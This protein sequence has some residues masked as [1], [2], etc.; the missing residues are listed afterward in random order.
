MK[1]KLLGKKIRE[2]EMQKIPYLVDYRRQ[3][4]FRKCS[5]RKRARKRRFGPN[6]TEKFI[7]K[8]KEEI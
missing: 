8:I 1:M 6:A 4:N 2:A 7:E 3:R 5:F